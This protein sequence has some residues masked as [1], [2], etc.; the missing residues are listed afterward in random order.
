MTGTAATEAEEFVEI[1]G[2]GVVE[3]P[4]NLPIARIDEDDAGLPHRRARNTTPSS[5]R[6]ASP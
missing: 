4:T 1:Y 3:V 5:R 6:S 2:L